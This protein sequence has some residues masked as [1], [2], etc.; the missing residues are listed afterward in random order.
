[1]LSLFV[2][3]LT[4]RDNQAGFLCDPMCFPSYAFSLL[5][6]DGDPIAKIKTLF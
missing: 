1:M 4:I 6:A 2:R 5:R 3:T